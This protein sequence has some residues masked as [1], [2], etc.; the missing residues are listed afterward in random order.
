M[1]K[2]PTNPNSAGNSGKAF[3]PKIWP[4][5][6]KPT[7]QTESWDERSGYPNW[8]VLYEVPDQRSSHQSAN[9]GQTT[10]RAGASKRRD[11][12]CHMMHQVR[13]S[14]RYRNFKAKLEAIWVKDEFQL[15]DLLPRAN[16]E[17]QSTTPGTGQAE[18][19]SGELTRALLH[20]F[21]C[22]S[23]YNST[24]GRDLFL[25]TSPPVVY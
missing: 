9:T 3:C 5:S 16:I 11:H 21:Y 22:I 25:M 20:C 1:G 17:S 7:A 2:Y 24:K 4:S 15:R 6:R 10:V 8:E 18:L 13:L 14:N 19:L 12:R 23:F